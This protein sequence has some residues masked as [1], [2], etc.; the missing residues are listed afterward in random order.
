MN[1]DVEVK[2][3]GKLESGTLRIRPITVV[4]GPNGTGKSF[5]TKTLYSLLNVLNKNL[6]LSNIDISCKKLLANLDRFMP[7]MSYAGWNDHYEITKAT[8]SIKDIHDNLVNSLDWNI[9]DYIN[10]AESKKDEVNQTKNDIKNYIST[11]KSKERKYDSVRIISKRLI[12]NFEDLEA[13][14][15]DG[16][17]KYSD[18]LAKSL[19]NELKENFQVTSLSDLVSNNKKKATFS[20]KN[21]FDVEFGNDGIGFN[22]ET[23]FIN[24]VSSLS[25]VVF[26]ESPAYWKVRDALLHSKSFSNMPFLGKESNNRLTGVPKYFYDLDIELRT[27]YKKDSSIHL[28]DICKTITKELGGEFQFNGDSLVFN[29]LKTNKNFSKNLISFGMT[30]LG[31]IHALIKNNVVSP[32]SFLF[33]DEPE[34]NLH[35]NWQVLLMNTLVGLAEKDVHVVIAT[36]SLEMLKALEVSIKKKKIVYE[37]FFSVNYFDLDHSTLEFDS[38]DPLEQLDEARSELSS[39]YSAL[40]FDGI[41]YD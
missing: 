33:I 35:P 39:A 31:M 14:L 1:F 28:E 29:D 4:T 36:H 11:L 2:N 3:L 23:N 18:A 26:F 24:E 5:F 16:M 9:Y 17:E 20:V 7:G 32:G 41:K 8:K 6:Y 25:R 22:I 13:L 27:E 21:K 12:D 38:N 15:T 30:N 34:T 37:N 40:Y 10:L 19:D